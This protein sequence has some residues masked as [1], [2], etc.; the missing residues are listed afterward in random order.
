CHHGA[1]LANFANYRHYSTASP[2]GQRKNAGEYCKKSPALF[3]HATAYCID[4]GKSAP[5]PGQTEKP[6]PSAPVFL[7]FY[8]CC[9]SMDK[10]EL[11][12]SHPFFASH[13]CAFGDTLDRL[14]KR[15]LQLPSHLRF[16]SLL[17]KGSMPG[18]I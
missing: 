7:S 5:F 10:G 17:S 14:W 9:G 2:G 12:P 3:W 4:D 15:M 1:F 18:T 13:R 6:E 8:F 11:F 16:V